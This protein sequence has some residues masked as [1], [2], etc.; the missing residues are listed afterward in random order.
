MDGK[1]LE[2]KILANQNRFAKFTN[3]FYCQRFTLY[4]IC[5]YYIVADKSP[6]LQLIHFIIYVE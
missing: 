3:V 5:N 2:G 4:S 1:T 6:E